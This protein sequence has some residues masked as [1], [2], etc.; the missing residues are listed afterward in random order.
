MGSENGE[1]RFWDLAARTLVRVIEA[2]DAYL[3]G[4]EIGGWNASGDKLVL[5][6]VNGTRSAGLDGRFTTSESP[7]AFPPGLTFH[8]LRELVTTASG[9]AGAI[10]ERKL[11]E[12]E[13]VVWAR[14]QLGRPPRTVKTNGVPLSITGSARR[15]LVPVVVHPSGDHNDDKGITNLHLVDPDT[16]D[17]GPAVASTPGELHIVATNPEASLVALGMQGGRLVLRDTRALRDRATF[18]APYRSAGSPAS[19]GFGIGAFTPDG[20]E[21]AVVV[22]G[23]LALYDVAAQRL[24]AT[25]GHDV[26]IPDHVA[27]TSDS[28]LVIASEDD[29]WL[30]RGT[31]LSFWSL[32]TGRMS[33]VASLPKRSALAPAPGGNIVAMRYGVDRR[34]KRGQLAIDIDELAAAAPAMNVKEPTE[35]VCI[36]AD[37]ASMVDPIKRRVVV[38][39]Y[40]VAP[41]SSVYDIASKTKTLL[42]Q[43]AGH[44][45]LWASSDGRWLA[46]PKAVWDA[47]TGAVLLTDLVDR[48]EKGA[49]LRSI[50]FSHDGNR[51]AI[52][53]AKIHLIELPTLRE[54]WSADIPNVGYLEI[55]SDDAVVASQPGGAIAV[56]R[57]G[58]VVATSQSGS[59]LLSMDLDPTRTMVATI[60]RDGGARV[61]DA[62]DGSLRATLYDFRDGEHMT[63]TSDGAYTGTAEVADRLAWVFDEPREAFRFEQYARIYDRPSR[64]REALSGAQVAK[65]PSVPRAP[66]IAL[67][68]APRVAKGVASVR[69]NVMS[70]SRVDVV[71]A[72]VEGRLVAQRAVCAATADVF[73]ELPLLAG[74]NR[75]TL[76]AFDDQ[77]FSSGHAVFDAEGPEPSGGGTRPKLWVLA[78][79]VSTYPRLSPAEQLDAADDDARAIAKALGGAVGP[80]ADKPFREIDSKVLVDGEVT[81][82]TVQ[83]ALD[84]MAGMSAD[85]V[86]FVFFAGHGVQIPGSQETVLL[87]SASAPTVLSMKTTALGWP[88]LSAR[89]AKLKGRVALLL[90]ACH[91]GHVSTA[92]I[93]PNEELAASLARES[94]AGVMIFAAAKGAQYSY[95][96]NTARGLV[97]EATQAAAIAVAA[98]AKGTPHGFFTAALLSSLASAGTDHDGDG[99]IEWSELV[100]EVKGRVTVASSGRQTPWESR[101]EVMGD[102]RLARA[103]RSR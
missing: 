38:N 23:A 82:E 72:Y 57:G 46:S 29:R 10:I 55:P 12:R 95:E 62:R 99:W 100:D 69:V 32:A 7:L 3:A 83:R 47:K 9:G 6:N 31:S 39:P 45:V 71:R 11:G 36:E 66:R 91:S 78:I 84:A 56:V 74:K 8:H 51:L 90:D 80:G 2:D 48:F 16:A 63:F 101:R 81:T 33:R 26:R 54:V 65:L 79:G 58:K 15:V 50:A 53:A 87:T 18:L 35:F 14:G 17:L 98:E 76:V 37:A 21:L 27:F 75:V 77:G 96:G 42:A 61:W 64:V 34:C 41:E 44:N 73:L 52:A 25:F 49:E 70:S 59:S 19:P 86:A 20:K 89:L 103:S 43:S 68:E 22:A 4:H 60:H 102:F 67:S 92:I 28:G 13:L 1:V 85:D 24:V 94:R 88:M 40:G 97:L 5:R 30:S 93:A